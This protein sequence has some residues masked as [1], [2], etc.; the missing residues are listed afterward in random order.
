MPYRPRGSQPP[1]RVALYH[2]GAWRRTRAAQLA[3]EPWCRVCGAIAVVADHVRPLRLGGR[4]LQSLCWRD[5]Q[6]KRATS[7]R[8]YPLRVVSAW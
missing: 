2:S 8:G 3:A 1:Q 7:D 4:E 6:R 5:H